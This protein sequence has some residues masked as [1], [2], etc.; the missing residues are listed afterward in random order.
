[1]VVDAARSPIVD[2]EYLVF[3]VVQLAEPLDRRPELLRSTDVR[4][5]DDRCPGQR[6]LRVR[7]AYIEIKCLAERLAKVA[8]QVICTKSLGADGDRGDADW[9]VAAHREDPD[10]LVRAP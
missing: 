2:D 4:R 9:A 5:N 7:A 8:L 1:L 3:R 10:R 6:D